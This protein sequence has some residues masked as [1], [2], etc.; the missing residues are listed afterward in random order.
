MI[1]PLLSKIGITGAIR[2]VWKATPWPLR[3]IAVPYNLWVFLQ[4]L[5]RSSSERELWKLHDY[6][7]IDSAVYRLICPRYT[8]I[9]SLLE[10]YGIKAG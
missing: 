1:E 8:V 5:R 6:E 4:F 10:D 7:L 9:A 3:P 2:L